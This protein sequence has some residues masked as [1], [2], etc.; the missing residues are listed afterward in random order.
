[1]TDMRKPEFKLTVTSKE[2]SVQ[3]VLALRASP[4]YIPD[5]KEEEVAAATEEAMGPYWFQTKLQEAREF[6]FTQ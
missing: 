5:E 2:I 3:S 6:F 4:T 1:M